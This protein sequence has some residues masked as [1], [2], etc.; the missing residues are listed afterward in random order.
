VAVTPALERARQAGRAAGTP[1]W[2]TWRSQHLPLSLRVR[3]R[4]TALVVG[5]T[6]L[7]GLVGAWSMTLGSFP[8]TLGEVAR[9]TVGA[10][11]EGR[12][13]FIVQTLRLP[14]VATGAMAGGALACSG[15]IFQGL[16]R[17]PL[18]APDIIGVTAG[19]AV[20][21]V[22]VIVTGQS[23][24]LLPVAAFAGAVVTA[25]AVYALTW[26][27][28]V[29]GNRLVLVGIGVNAALMALVTLMLVRFPIERVSQAVRWQTGTLYGS[30]RASVAALAVGL[31]VLLPVGLWLTRHLQ[32]LALG[33]DL[34]RALG[35]RAEAARGGLLVVG[36]GLAAVA[37]AAGGPIGFVALISPHIARMLA[38]PTTGGIMLLSG[39]VGAVLVLTSDV[40]AQHAFPV[41]LPVGVVTAAVGAP[42]FLLL[43]YR[44]NRVV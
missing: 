43:L 28:G 4:T 40:A 34:A 15:A 24:A 16:V 2:I 26:R 12:H 31:A 32:A 29:A 17:N 39:A 36:S 37:V 13:E 11:A 10:A 42:Y 9:A 33:D 14:R 18:V 44:T 3:L 30:D 7:A 35:V 23:P 6:V 21:A 38:G 19:A 22:A 1:R 8:L 20:A 25:F 41:S 5:V 27:S